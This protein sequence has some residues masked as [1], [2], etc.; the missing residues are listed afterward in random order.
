MDPDP[1]LQPEPFNKLT[2]VTL[3]SDK[4]PHAVI[5]YTLDGSTPTSSSTLYEGPIALQAPTT[6]RALAT[7]DDF[8]PSDVITKNFRFRAVKPRAKSLDGDSQ[9]NFPPFFDKPQTVTLSTTTDGAKIYY[10][11]DGKTPDKDNSPQYVSP[12]V[13]TENTPLKAIA[14]KDGWEKS[15]ELSL[16]YVIKITT[17]TEPVYACLVG[18]WVC[19]AVTTSSP[20]TKPICDSIGFNYEGTTDTS[21]L[22]GQAQCASSCQEYYGRLSVK[23]VQ[24]TPFLLPDSCPQSV[25]SAASRATSQAACQQLQ[26]DNPELAC[27]SQK[28]LLFLKFL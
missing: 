16:D 4:T 1:D 14:V 19:G 8:T 27:H 21:G 15:E 26:D 10:T 23:D 11:V 6:V 18:E 20:V 25:V 5:Y 3:W 17:C 28:S 13:I 2:K 12:I 22:C 24:V 9:G 7:R